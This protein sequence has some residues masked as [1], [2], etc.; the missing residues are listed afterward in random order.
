MSAWALFA[1]LGFYPI[2]GTTKYL[3]GSPAV[4]SAA[5]QLPNGNKVR[6]RIS[7]PRHVSFSPLL[8]LIAADCNTNRRSIEV[9]G[10]R[11]QIGC[12]WSDDISSSSDAR[13]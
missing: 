8:Y 7:S 5:L 12:E 6:P 10:I 3:I 11:L 1:M 13:S 4:E 2:A 9:N